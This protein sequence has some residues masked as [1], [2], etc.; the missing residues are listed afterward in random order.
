MA[1]I[2]RL[3]KSYL[4]M[5]EASFLLLFCL[6]QENHG[7]GIMQQVQELRVAM[8]A[9]TVYTIL[10]KMENDG[11]IEVTR[12][13]ERRKLYKITPVGEAI[14]EKETERIRQLARIA[15]QRELVGAQ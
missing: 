13:F 10:Y 7:Y 11:L 5:S 14:L 15:D 3:I 9:G 12:T 8:G 2:E 4:P 6:Q 1:E